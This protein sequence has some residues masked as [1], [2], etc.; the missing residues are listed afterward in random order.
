MG[1][2]KTVIEKNVLVILMHCVVSRCFLSFL[3][4]SNFLDSG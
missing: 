2:E 1:M 3:P 4:M